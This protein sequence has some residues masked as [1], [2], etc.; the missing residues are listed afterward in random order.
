MTEITSLMKTIVIGLKYSLATLNQINEN[1]QN[2][3]EST[4]APYV[5]NLMF[6]F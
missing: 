4:T 3:I 6:T 2:T 1:D 5:L